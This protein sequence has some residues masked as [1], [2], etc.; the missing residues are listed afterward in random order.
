MPSIKQDIGNPWIQERET[1]VASWTSN[2]DGDTLC[3][4]RDS[5][6][7]QLLHSSLCLLKPQNCFLRNANPPDW[8]RLGYFYFLWLPEEETY[9][10]PGSQ[11]CPSQLC[12]NPT[13]SYLPIHPLSRFGLFAYLWGH[14]L[15]PGSESLLLLP[16]PSG[17]N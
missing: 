14:P 17:S 2:L 13:P 4:S 12:E 16:L 8:A 5:S 3:G 1:V 15:V 6:H 10:K 9:Y 7:N 11:A